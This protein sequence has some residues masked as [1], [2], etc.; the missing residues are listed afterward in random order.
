MYRLLFLFVFLAQQ[1]FFA[2]IP[3]PDFL[4]AMQ[5]AKELLLEENGP[6]GT[7][8]ENPDLSARQQNLK[9]FQRN[10]L[11]NLALTKEGFYRIPR[12]VHQIWLGSAVPT[13]YHKWMQSWMHWNGWEY[14]LWTDKDVKE[15]GLYNQKLYD[16]ATNYGE[17]SDILRLEILDR[18]GGLYVDTDFQCVNAETFDELHRSF[19]LY[20]GF[21]P[22]SHGNIH[23]VNKIC[24]ALMAACPAHPLIQ[25]LIVNMEANWI[26]H[27]E[28]SAIQKCGPNYL[29]YTIFDYELPRQ[30]DTFRNMYFPC[31]F[32][33]PISAP[34]MY[35][36][37]SA[38]EL[39]Q[40]LSPE[41]A[42]IHYW[43]GSWWLPESK[44][45][46]DFA[47]LSPYG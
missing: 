39:L 24:N 44:T 17:R 22:G 29:T 2:A 25:R 3:Y 31:S 19:D 13:K 41:T 32:F 6:Y 7:T 30:E 35:H 40:K 10:Y 37:K 45:K 43:S 42:A 23:H 12:I 15:F 8:E 28:E 36:A 34:E 26:K 16:L 47:K 18:F 5:G 27:Q 46:K 14:R 9:F 38:Q 4:A 1:L 20:V 33:Y 21:E 11:K